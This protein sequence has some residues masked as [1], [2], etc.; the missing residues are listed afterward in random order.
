MKKTLQEIEEFLDK[1]LTWATLNNLNDQTIEAN[2]T[3]YLCKELMKECY[4]VAPTKT[5][6]P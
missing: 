6:K 4:G 3:I 5:D 2:K 1:R